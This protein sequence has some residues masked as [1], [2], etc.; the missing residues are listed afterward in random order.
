MSL[1]SKQT[2]PTDGAVHLFLQEHSTNSKPFRGSKQPHISNLHLFTDYYDKYPKYQKYNYSNQ[3]I[4][5]SRQWGPSM[6][7]FRHLRITYQK[8]INHKKRI[9]GQHLPNCEQPYFRVLQYLESGTK[10]VQ[11]QLIIYNACDPTI[12]YDP[13]HVWVM[14]KFWLWTESQARLGSSLSFHSGMWAISHLLS[15]VGSCAPPLDTFSSLMEPICL[16]VFTSSSFILVQLHKSSFILTLIPDTT[17]TSQDAPIGYQRL[18][19]IVSL[20]TICSIFIKVKAS[21]LITSAELLH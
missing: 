15:G 3:M 20:S 4:P 11:A 18:L 19:P 13:Y 10:M 9:V 8:C 16:I 1:S 5:D 14:V 2:Q 7:D 17:R 21:R 6:V 12:I